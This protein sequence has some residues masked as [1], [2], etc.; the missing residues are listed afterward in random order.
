MRY[1]YSLALYLA[2]PYIIIR[3]WRRS[4]KFPAYKNRWAERFSFVKPPPLTDPIWIHAVSFGEVVVAEPLIKALLARYP[5]RSLVV[6]TMTPTGSERVCKTFGEQI[7]HVYVPYDLPGAVRRFFKQSRPTLGIIME[8]ELW[9]NMLYQVRKRKLPLLLANAR[10]S[11]RSTRG[12]QRIAGLTRH[13]LRSFTCVAAQSKVDAERF[14]QLGLAADKVMVTGSIKFD[15]TPPDAQIQEGRA[16]R[17][18]WSMIRPILIAASTHQGEE[19]QMLDAFKS[20][21]QQHPNALL[22]LVPRH[23]QR[24]DSV[25]AL[26]EHRGYSIIRRSEGR[27][28]E[29]STDIF[30][31]DSMGEMYM[32]YALA[33]VAF[34]GGSLVSVG[35]HNLLEPAALGLPV[36]TG[37][38][39]FN[40]TEISQLLRQADAITVVNNADELAKHVIAL[41]QNPQSR[42]QQGHRGL[43][44]LAQ[45]RGA[46]QKHLD[47]IAQ[48]F[49]PTTENDVVPPALASHY[50][51]PTR[52]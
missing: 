27:T 41:F 5:Q 37:P 14:I 32:Y 26:C 36:L 12:Y 6:T 8:T 7:Y 50:S 44:V 11:P 52:S 49:P 23:P 45:N 31:G 15:I 29:P 2:L 40:F 24:F 43:R 3:L 16:L 47:W 19:D 21:K 51:E 33:D 4:R 46:L 17:H 18:S 13:M 48:Q 39:L 22:I 38:Q 30:L 9:P 34:V 25:A 1:L 42:Q 28:C 20:I 10:L 35:G